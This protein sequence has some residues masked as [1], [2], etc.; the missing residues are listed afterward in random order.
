MRLFLI[1]VLMIF[2][3]GC[4]SASD[5]VDISDVVV[6]PPQRKQIDRSRLGVH[7]FFIERGAFGNV[8]SQ[9]RDIRNN[10][11]IRFVRVLVPWLETKQGSPSAEYNFE[12]ADSILKSIPPGVDVLV[13][14]A[15]TPSWFGN[16]SNWIGGNPRTTWVERFLKPVVTRYK[17]TPGIVGWE[18]FNEPDVVTVPTDADLELADPANYLE[19][20]RESFNAIRQIDPERLVVMAATRSIQQDWP[21]NFNYN[22]TLRDLGVLDFTDVYNIHYYGQ[23]FEKVVA[24]NGVRD[25]LNGVGKPI[26]IT[27]SGE[28][29][30][31]NQLAYVETVWP[32]LDE[33][34]NGIDRFYYYEYASTAPSPQSFG[35]RSTDPA[36]PVSDL[37]VWLRDRR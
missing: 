21:N 12:Q 23:Q 32:F 3:F 31:N 20:L 19:L 7:N 9:Y 30:P 11:G 1:L 33:E 24:R 35:M 14:L 29:G 4:N 10:L 6:N 17:N 34:I 37:Y 18:V 26:W 13:V 22:R 36:F 15:H 27:E 25:F 8:Q 2:S 28:L 5:L 16:R